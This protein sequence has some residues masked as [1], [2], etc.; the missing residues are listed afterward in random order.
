MDRIELVLLHEH[1][2]RRAVELQTDQRVHAGLGVQDP[3]QDLRVHGD[4]GGVAL[5]GTV[6]NRRDPAART[7][8][9]RLVLAA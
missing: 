8:P 6:D 7:Q 9:A 1:P 5:V 4:L 2:R 3:R